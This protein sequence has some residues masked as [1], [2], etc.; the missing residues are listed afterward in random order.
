MFSDPLLPKKLD[1]LGS[2]GCQENFA[3]T[4][5]T[6]IEIFSCR[7]AMVVAE[8]ADATVTVALDDRA[9]GAERA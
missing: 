6:K 5:R 2:R 7:P 3:L 8:L 9:I 4:R 1:L